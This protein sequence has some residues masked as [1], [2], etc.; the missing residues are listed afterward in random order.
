M[1]GSS[2]RALRL[3]R[4]QTAQPKTVEYQF[5][6]A[7]KVPKLGLC[8]PSSRP[9]APLAA[10]GAALSTG[11]M[12][13]CARRMLVGW[14]GNNGSTTTAGVIANKMKMSWETK[15]GNAKCIFTGE[16]R[17]ARTLRI[18]STCCVA[19]ALARAASPLLPPMG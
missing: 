15:E 1:V 16:R 2:P 11:S 5:R 14:G 6:T 17:R 10:P 18:L 13:S 12:L 3:V 19:C 8:A 4:S 7:R 9:R